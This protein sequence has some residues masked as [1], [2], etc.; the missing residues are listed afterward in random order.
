MVVMPGRQ[1]LPSLD[2][3]GAQCKLHVT[4]QRCQGTTG[5]VEFGLVHCVGVKLKE[6]RK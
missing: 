4:L 5:Q 6:N 2:E 1:N 3:N